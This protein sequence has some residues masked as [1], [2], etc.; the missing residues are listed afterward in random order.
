M[1]PLLKIYTVWSLVISNIQP[2]SSSTETKNMYANDVINGCKKQERT[3]LQ[4]GDNSDLSVV[5]AKLTWIV[6]IIAA[7]LKSRQCIGCR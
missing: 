2:F 5:E 3:Q 4:A 7:I 6:H 1:E